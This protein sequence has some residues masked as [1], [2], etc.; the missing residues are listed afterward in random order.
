VANSSIEPRQRFGKA[1]SVST[2]ANIIITDRE[3]ELIFYRHSD[4]YP[5]GTLP[6]LTKFLDLVK[7]GVI[8]DNVGQACGWL[9][10]IGA[11]EYG[12]T[13]EYDRLP[14]CQ[15]GPSMSWKVGA[16]EPTT[17]LHGDIE[18]LYV[19]DLKDKRIIHR[20]VKRDAEFNLV[21]PRSFYSGLFNPV[22][23]ELTSSESVKGAARNGKT[24]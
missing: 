6:T 15:R 8:R 13:F 19:I 17:R 10:L 22:R 1:K 5:D 3:D 9:I 7:D 18:F 24:L 14:A 23:C 4:G 11:R 20:K 2:R 21:V 16:Y 12:V